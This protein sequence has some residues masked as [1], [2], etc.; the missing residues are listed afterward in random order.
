MDEHLIYN[1]LEYN[2]F[3]YDYSPLFTN[4]ELQHKSAYKYVKHQRE[5]FCHII[6]EHFSR[7]YYL[8]IIAGPPTQVE[9]DRIFSSMDLHGL[10]RRPDYYD[11]GVYIRLFREFDTHALGCYLGE[12]AYPCEKICKHKKYKSTLLESLTLC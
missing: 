12:T 10:F 7:L 6:E 4:K 3:N 5:R 1:I 9:V 8:H 11:I 2:T